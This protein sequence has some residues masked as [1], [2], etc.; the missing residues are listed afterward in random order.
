MREALGLCPWSKLLYATH[1]TALPDAY[2]VAAGRHRE[3]L[4]GAC[5]ELVQAATLAEGEAV[6]VGRRVLAGDAA[7]LYRLEG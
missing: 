5:A 3:A 1:A 2:L 7:E 4:A 6:E